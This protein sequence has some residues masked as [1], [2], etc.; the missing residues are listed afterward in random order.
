MRGEPQSL[1]LGEVHQGLGALGWVLGSANKQVGL[2]EDPR[3]FLSPYGL[4][5]IPAQ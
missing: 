4:P 1:D 2:D 5:V 3:D